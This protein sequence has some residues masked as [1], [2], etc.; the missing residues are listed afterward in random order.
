MLE[1]HAQSSR[2]KRSGMRQRVKK[3]ILFVG[4]GV[5]FLLSALLPY[6]GLLAV[7][8]PH[9]WN[10]ILDQLKAGCY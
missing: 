6:P 9:D 1:K 5:G 8:I 10:D 3:R 4:G 2:Q 7:F